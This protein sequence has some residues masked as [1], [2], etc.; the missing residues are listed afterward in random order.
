MAAS[1]D[2][3]ALPLWSCL[4]SHLSSV[5]SY[6]LSHPRRCSLAEFSNTLTILEKTKSAD[7]QGPS[8][9]GQGKGTT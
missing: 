3:A 1:S 5:F 7:T 8:W 6:L 9:V 2:G 4:P